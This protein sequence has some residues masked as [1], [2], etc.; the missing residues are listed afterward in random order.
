MHSFEDPGS[1]SFIVR[2]ASDGDVHTGG[3]GFLAI[4]DGVLHVMTA[5]HV[6]TGLTE[7]TPDWTT[8]HDELQIR[9]GPDAD[10]LEASFPM[11]EVRNDEVRP[12]FKYIRDFFR[13]GILVDVLARPVPNE[14]WVANF[15]H[16]DLGSGLRRLTPPLLE[17]ELIAWGYPVVEG[18]QPARAAIQGGVVS[19]PLD[20]VPDALRATLGSEIGHSGAPVFTALGAFV[21]MLT[22]ST[23][24]VEVILPP[25][26]LRRARYSPGGSS[27]TDNY[28]NF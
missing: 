20:N 12:L 21:G 4:I 24:S 22:G 11:F 2:G 10:Y 27:L 26:L 17:E 15:Q 9:R 5:A 18:S 7:Q 13:P 25:G 6:L 14:G 19:L 16:I 23:D 28:S 1:L 3:T 8:W